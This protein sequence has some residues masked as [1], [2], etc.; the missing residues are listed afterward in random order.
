MEH[1]LSSKSSRIL[2]VREQTKW[3]FCKKQSEDETWV[4]KESR[5]FFFLLLSRFKFLDVLNW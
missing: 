4:V 2:G 5:R 3:S 1:F